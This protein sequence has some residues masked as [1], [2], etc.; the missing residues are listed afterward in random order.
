MTERGRPFPGT[1]FIYDPTQWRS[2]AGYPP[3]SVFRFP[4]SEQN[5]LALSLIT[6]TMSPLPP[7]QLA[8]Q[9]K[10]KCHLFF[11]WPGELIKTVTYSAVPRGTATGRLPMTEVT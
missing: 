2:L 1:G 10:V 5:H 8:R 9:L 11:F 7:L 4:A 3:L 6:H